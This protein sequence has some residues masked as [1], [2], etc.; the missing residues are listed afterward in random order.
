MFVCLYVC[1]VGLGNGRVTVVGNEGTAAEK[2]FWA[3]M[4]R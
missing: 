1:V 2:G 4:N 3:S